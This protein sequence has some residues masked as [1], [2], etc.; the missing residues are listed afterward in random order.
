M[1]LFFTSYK[2]TPCISLQASIHPMLLFSCSFQFPLF[3]VNCFDFLC[4]QTPG[5]IYFVSPKDFGITFRDESSGL[6]FHNAGGRAWC[7]YST[8]AREVSEDLGWGHMTQHVELEGTSTTGSWEI[9]RLTAA[10]VNFTLLPSRSLSERITFPKLCLA[11]KVHILIIMTCEAL[12]EGNILFLL[13]FLEYWRESMIFIS[14]LRRFRDLWEENHSSPF[15]LQHLG[16]KTHR[17]YYTQICFMGYSGY[18]FAYVSEV[19][20]MLILVFYREGIENVEELTLSGRA[21]TLTKD[22]VNT[23]YTCTLYFKSFWIHRLITPTPAAT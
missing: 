2:C 7:E 20:N 3:F 11:K 1:T 4:L 16:Y 17:E 8:S 6:H 5:Y 10:P 9:S 15:L 19:T 18:I 12:S 22:G 13:D 14:T 23:V 21:Y